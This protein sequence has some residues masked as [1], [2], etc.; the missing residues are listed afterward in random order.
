MSNSAQHPSVC[1]LLISYQLCCAAIRR[2]ASC[3]GDRAVF[4][5]DVATGR[6]IRKFRGHDGV[7]N[8]V[9]RVILLFGKTSMRRLYR[10]SVFCMQIAYAAG[11]EVLVTGGYDQAI[12]LWDCR[13]RSFEP[14][15]TLKNFG[16]AVT[17][18]AVADRQGHTT[19]TLCTAY[20]PAYSVHSVLRL[21]YTADVSAKVTRDV[22]LLSFLS[23]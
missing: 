1:S 16:D 13:S 8:S 20:L 3:G 23:L 17:S 21:A 7:A 10:L 14:I 18:V 4:S 22:S 11:D 15:Q 2:L 5:W 12:R 19:C 9:S 6:I